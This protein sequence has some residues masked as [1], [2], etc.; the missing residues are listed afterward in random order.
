MKFSNIRSKRMAVIAGVAA[1]AFIGLSSAYADSASGKTR[2][3]VKAELADAIR[4]G[5]IHAGGTVSMKLNELFPEQYPA[6]S[7]AAGKT[8]QQVKAE[9][10]QA[11][12]TGDIEVGGVASMK[13]NELFPGLYPSQSAS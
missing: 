3:Q 9:L 8:R 12:R 13:L 4:T 10:A 1:A 7:T 6:K 5:D 2:A 11:T